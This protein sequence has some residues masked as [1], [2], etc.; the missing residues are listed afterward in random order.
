MT[1]LL[2]ADKLQF[3]IELV[4]KVHRKFDM[5]EESTTPKS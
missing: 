3:I 4:Y 2:F 5:E 1:T